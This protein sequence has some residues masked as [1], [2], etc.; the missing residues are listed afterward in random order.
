ML[1]DDIRQRLFSPT[2]SASPRAVGAELEL[3]PV[4]ARTKRVVPAK[5][6]AR[7]S[8]GVISALADREGWLE[9]KNDHDP[10]SWNLADGARISFEPG[11]QIEISSS[12]HHTASSLISALQ[13]LAGTIQ[14]EMAA[15]GI[16]LLA[17]GVDPYNDIAAV[18]LQLHRDRYTRMTDFFNS[19][20]P[21][22]VRMM[23][24]TAALQINVERGSDPASRWRLLNAIAPLVTALFAN[25][26]A[27]AGADTDHASYRAHLW[28]TLDGSRTGLA[29]DGKDPAYHYLGFALN[30]LAMRSGTG[31]PTRYGS[32][33]TWMRRVDLSLDDWHFHL[34]TLF[35]EV[36]PK[37][38]FELRS[39][40][41]VDIQWLAAPI[42]FVTG[43]I[44]DPAAADNATRL[45]G[46]PSAELL[47]RAGRLGLSDPDLKRLARAAVELSLSGARALGPGYLEA[48]HLDSAREYFTRA[49]DG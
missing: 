15:E 2:Q 25:S 9:E 48:G 16:E 38:Y 36:R 3:I 21:S 24:Q 19:L 34:S 45:L 46:A 32:F 30:A 43:L 42:V 10:S 41:T 8:G 26:Q 22:G 17:R 18:P 47:E 49:L 37:A 11:G 28:R 13:Q 12:A 35:P 14:R 23:R 20:G 27:Y 6:G 31:E 1:L 33:L 39:A 44:Y 4:D 7:S 5:G 29:W 40:D